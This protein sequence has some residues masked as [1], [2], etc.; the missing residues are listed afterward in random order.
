M[1]LSTLYDIATKS[2][3]SIKSDKPIQ[4]AIDLI[5]KHS[6]RTVIVEDDNNQFFTLSVNDIIA[7]DITEDRLNEP[8]SSLSLNKLL[9]INKNSTLLEALFLFDK[10][11][12]IIGISDDDGKLV[13][14]VTYSNVLNSLYGFSDD[15]LYKPIGSLIS[16]NTTAIATIGEMLTSHL[17]SIEKATADCLIVVDED[18][19][20]IG[21]ITKRDIVKMIGKKVSLAQKVENLMSYPLSCLN[22]GVTINEALN[23]MRE[24]KLKRV[25]V[26]DSNKKLKGVITQ[27]NLL[28]IIYSRFA[29][30][31]V[32]TLEKINKILEEQVKNRTQ[33]LLEMNAKLE[34]IVEEEI[35]KRRAQEQLSIQQSKMAALGE[36]LHHIAHHWRQ[37]LNALAINIQYMSELF[38]YDELTKEKMIELKDAAMKL[39]KQM[40]SI[41][42]SFRKNFKKSEEIVCFGIVNTIKDVIEIIYPAFNSKNYELKLVT[43]ELNGTDDI[44]VEGYLGEFKLA[45]LSILQNSFDAL[46]GLYGKG[47]KE[48]GFTIIRVFKEEPKMVVISIEDNGGGTSNEVISKIGSPYFTTKKDP[49]A[50]G[51]G[52]FMCKTIIEKHTN[53]IIEFKNIDN[54]FNVIVKLPTINKVL[55]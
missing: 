10:D 25:I 7:N 45:I 38:E 28:D 13:G 29:Q 16:T 47:A 42:D 53:G 26:L 6:I 33:Q 40:S 12:A 46:D 19:Y 43:D 23:F 11:R 49:R 18:E 2:V 32:L 52:L 27:K 36:M 41:I 17:D 34:K 1:E 55:G 54:G 21:I 44:Y 48:N 51:T 37:P 39:I 50:T 30:K 14:V 35:N 20:P 5:A 3:I 8:I 4:N 31:G 24:K 9:I 22:E 15:S